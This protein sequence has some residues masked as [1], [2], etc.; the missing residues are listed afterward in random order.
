MGN[1][2]IYLLSSVSAFANRGS[3]NL[4]NYNG[5]NPTAVAQLGEAVA[6]I[7]ALSQDA[8]EITKRAPDMAWMV[9]YWDKTDAIVEGE[10][11]VRTAAETYLPK[12]SD[13]T[14]DEFQNR[15]RLTKFTN[16]FRDIL[17]GLASKPFEEEITLVESENEPLPEEIKDFAEDV[18]G[19]GNN[20]T[21]FAALT[22]FNG[23]ASAIDWIMIDAPVLD[24]TIIRT[25]ADQKKAGIKPYWSHV[26][27]RNVLEAKTEKSNGKQVLTYVRIFE[28]GVGEPDRVRIM[29]LSGT[30]GVT[31]ELWEKT[32]KDKF[33]KVDEGGLTINVIPLVPFITGR[34]DGKSWKVYPAMQDAA[35]LQIQLYQDE[36]ALK[37][38]K[39][40]TGYAMLAANGMVPEMMPD[41]KTAKPIKTGPSRVLWGLPDGNG[42]HGEWKYVEP[43]AANLKFLKEDIDETKKDLRELGRQPLTAQAGNMTTITAAMAAGKA[44]SAVSAWAL[45]LKD[46]LEN[47]LL[48]TWKFMKSSNTDGYE[49]EVNVYTEFDSFADGN[50]DM[51]ILT[52]MRKNGDLSRETLWVEAKRRKVLSPEFDAEMEEERILEEIPGDPDLENTDDG[53]D[54][55]NSVVD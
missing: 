25:I 22:F 11:A 35:D 14:N 41:G 24:T 46:A 5:V 54:N 29:Q 15:L 7:E 45:G 17:E 48:I 4:A 3:Q 32:E 36:S 8:K 13:E 53:Q 20:L 33:V 12:F 30:D 44:R 2:R 10:A 40:M 47:A 21:A 52:D 16:I 38:A 51:T 55:G 42:N 6:E 31:W 28:P 9:P 43:T 23:I 49:P 39:T 50:N 18:D 34:R 19:D 27:G 26:L 1:Y 37:F